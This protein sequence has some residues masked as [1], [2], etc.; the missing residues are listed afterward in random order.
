MMAKYGMSLC[1]LGIAE[2]LRVRRHRVQHVVAAHAGGHRRGAESA[3]RRR[4]DGP[5]AQ[6]GDVLRRRVRHREQAVRE[7]TGNTL[8]CEDVLLESGVNDLSVYNCVPAAELGVDF[9]VDGA[10]RPDTP[11]PD[12]VIAS[13]AKLGAADH[14]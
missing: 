11:V 3:R 12:V 13:A 1:A 2:E 7:Y 4:G 14:R 10:T 9:W 5:G 8:L 6:A